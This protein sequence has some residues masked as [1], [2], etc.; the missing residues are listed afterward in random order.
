MQIFFLNPVHLVEKKRITIQMIPKL[1]K[2]ST[3]K[4]VFMIIQMDRLEILNSTI[5]MKIN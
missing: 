3:V 2:K 1:K 5:L 4:Q